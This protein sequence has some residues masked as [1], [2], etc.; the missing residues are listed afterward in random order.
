VVEPVSELSDALAVGAQDMRDSYAMGPRLWYL[1]LPPWIVE[2][3]GGWDVFCEKFEES[4]ERKME[5][6]AAGIKG[7]EVVTDWNAPIQR[8]TLRRFRDSGLL[9]DLG[10]DQ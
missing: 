7:F 3:A 2:Q 5:L 10:G 8:Y 4:Y 9:P 6:Q 1:A